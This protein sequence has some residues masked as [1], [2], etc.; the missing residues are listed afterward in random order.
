[1]VGGGAAALVAF[2][3]QLDVYS[4]KQGWLPVPP[5]LLLAAFGALV[6]SV[7]LALPRPERPRISLEGWVRASGP[8]LVAMALFVLWGLLR[9]AFAA[10]PPLDLRQTLLP[11]VDFGVVLVGAAAGALVRGRWRSVVV[12][13]FGLVLLSVLVDGL[14]PGTFSKQLARAAGLAGN[15]NE[16]GFRLVLLA[17]AGIRYH[18][19]HRADLLVVAACGLG[20]FLT[21]SRGALLLFAVWV[22]MYGFSLALG[23]RQPGFWRPEP[24]RR[25]RSAVVTAVGLLALAATLGVGGSLIL[26]ELPQFDTYQGQQRLSMLA[27]L[28]S[29]LQ[30]SGGTRSRLVAEGMARIDRRPLLGYGPGF[31]ASLKPG[32]H[33]QYLKIWL[34]QG[35]PGVLLFLTV[36]LSAVGVFWA[37]RSFAG[38][39]L[40]SLL[41]MKAFF[42][43][44]M[45]D[46]RTSL[47]L[48]GVLLTASL[49]KNRGRESIVF[50]SM[51]PKRS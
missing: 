25:H 12:A 32:P 38:L 34:D 13:A 15:A 41:A 44:N 36:L 8:I 22:V 9:S 7:L 28:D 4:A 10:Q 31:S 29:F 45:L 24:R 6:G 40:V 42:A 3:A 48:L 1:M 14:V 17:A 30:G 27:S 2:L 21:L 18:R 33:N 16:G 37:R 51:K 49:V 20:V 35:F 43:H 19:L 39:I 11:L 5:I 26:S 50:E 46:D 47:L 23:A